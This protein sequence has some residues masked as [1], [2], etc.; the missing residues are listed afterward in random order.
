MTAKSAAEVTAP[1]VLLALLAQT[2]HRLQALLHL[3][4]IVVTIENVN[5]TERAALIAQEGRQERMN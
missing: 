1:Q 4:L 5:L 2:L 3:H